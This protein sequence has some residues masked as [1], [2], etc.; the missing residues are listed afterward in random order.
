[1]KSIKKSATQKDV[2]RHANVSQAAVSSVLSGNGVGISQPVQ[3][4]IRASA[5]ALNYMPNR[6]AQAL[7]TNRSMMIACIV[8]DI[9]NPFYPPL[10][11]AVQNAVEP[12]GYDVIA[13]SSDGLGSAE[14]RLLDL[15]LDRR[16]AGIVG[17]FFVA[18]ARDLA[19]VLDAGIPV[20]RYESAAKRGGPLAIDDYYVD[21]AQ[22]ASTLADRL[23]DLGHQRITFMAS[24]GGPEHARVSGYK[25][26]LTAAGLTANV[27]VSE[28]YSI[29]GGAACAADLVDAAPDLRP[30]AI[31]CADDLLAFGAIRACRAAGLVLPQ[32]MSVT[33]FNNLSLSDVLNPSLT[34]VSLSQELFGRQ[35]GER[36]LARI[37]G[38]QDG[39]GETV[40][41]PFSIVARGSMVSPHDGRAALSANDSPAG[42][43]Q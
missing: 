3:D 12:A 40:P 16:V 32:D 35:A 6:M 30:T 2:A 36:L 28:S 1:M 13:L 34:T 33:G 42:N 43:T 17:V 24:P 20:V 26:A 14:Q 15:C 8:P 22:A 11:R 19:G 7:K 10:I 27:V 4:R 9:S 5:K 38:K 41:L 18:T 23:I 37:E 29:D 39:P 25:A 31:M 21:N